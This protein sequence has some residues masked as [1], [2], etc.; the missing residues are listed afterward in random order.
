MNENELLEQRRQRFK[1][2]GVPE[3]LPPI[4]KSANPKIF[5]KIEEIKK[6]A[7]RFAFASTVASTSDVPVNPQPQSNLREGLP[8]QRGPVDPRKP[9]APPLKTFSA[10]PDPFLDSVNKMFDDTPSSAPYQHGQVAYGPQN[11][12]DGGQAW[13]REFSGRINS[14]A[15]K[16]NM[17]QPYNPQMQQEHYQPNNPQYPQYVPTAPIIYPS[18]TLVI[19]EKDLEDKIEKT[20]KRTAESAI[21]KVLD[22]Y[23]KTAKKG[24]VETDKIRKAEVIAENLVRVDG[25]IYQLVPAPKQV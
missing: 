15:S 22:V 14:H 10:K 25:K 7:H 4:Q 24:I 11:E 3:P 2:L 13:A 21:H 20:A 8:N 23:T 5:S 18:G 16:A 9:V 19:N 17:Q 12:N 6:G 1:D